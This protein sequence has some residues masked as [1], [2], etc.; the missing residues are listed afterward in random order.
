[1]CESRA[2]RVRDSHTTHTGFTHDSHTIRTRFTHDSHTIHTLLPH[3]SHSIHTRFTLDS[4]TIHTRFA[5]D[6]HSIHTQFSIHTTIHI[7][8]LI[9]FAL[10]SHSLAEHLTNGVDGCSGVVDMVSGN[11]GANFD[12]NIWSL[13]LLFF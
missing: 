3:D 12:A 2:N 8:L 11:E 13:C 4:H 6:S 10:S 1:M 9:L 5:H 7:T